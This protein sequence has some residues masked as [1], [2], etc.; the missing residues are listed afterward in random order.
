MK[1]SYFESDFFPVTSQHINMKL[2]IF[3]TVHNQ[4]FS[5][6]PLISTQDQEF[7]NNQI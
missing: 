5:L 7:R 6:Y 3:I 2:F 1:F 4:A